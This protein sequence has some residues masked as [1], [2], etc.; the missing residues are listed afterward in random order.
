MLL[1]FRVKFVIQKL[2]AH[3]ENSVTRH[4]QRTLFAYV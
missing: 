4:R 3:F 2:M 1:L